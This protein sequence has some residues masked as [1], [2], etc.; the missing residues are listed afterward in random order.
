[1]APSAVVGTVTNRRGGLV[2]VRAGLIVGATAAAA[3]VAGTALAFLTPPRAGNALFAGLLGVS[4]IQLAIR[5]RRA[6][7]QSL[8]E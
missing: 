5:A 8:P 6:G 1:M 2:D 4:A 7:P 3:S